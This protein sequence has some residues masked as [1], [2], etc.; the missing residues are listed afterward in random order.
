MYYDPIRKI[1][2]VMPPR[3]G[4]TTFSNLLKSWGVPNLLSTNKHAKP[5]ESGIENLNDYTFYG[6][7]R[8]PL[9]RFLS[10]LRFLQQMPEMARLTSSLIGINQKEFENLSLNDL[11]DNFPKYENIFP[12]YFNSQCKWLE[13]SVALDFNNYAAE[14]LRVARMFGVTQVN[15][16]VNN[17]TNNFQETTPQKVIDFVQ[18]YYADDY[19]LGR[20]RGLLI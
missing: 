16:A 18:S 14:I 5:N 6:F 10:L 1:A 12:F 11:I 19:S 2:F 13:N 20:E 7:Y 8:N 4:S 15:L 17:W 9:D 3:T